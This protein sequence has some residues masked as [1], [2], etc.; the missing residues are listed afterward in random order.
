M[1]IV[2]VE[3]TQLLSVEHG[4]GGLGEVAREVGSQGLDST[5]PCIG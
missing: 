3:R 2:K 1:S 4:V 5:S